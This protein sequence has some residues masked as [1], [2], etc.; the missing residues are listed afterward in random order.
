MHVEALRSGRTIL[1]KLRA[2]QLAGTVRLDLACGLTEFP[3]EIFDLADSLEIL[4]LSGNALS[5]LPDDLPRLDKLR[6]LFCSGNQFTK[7]PEVLGQCK[8]LTMLGFKANQISHVPEAALAPSLQW[9][10]LTDNRIRQLPHSIG[11]CKQMQK[12]MLAGNQLSDLPVELA[13]CTRLELLRLSANQFTVLPPWLLGMPNLA[14]LALAGNP[15]TDGFETNRQARQINDIDWQN[16]TLGRQLG[17]GASGVIY[18]AKLQKTEGATEDVAVKL[19][20][21]AV[22]SDG[23]PRCEMAAC[24][25]VDAHPHVVS[26]MGR[27]VEHPDG[28][29]GLVMPL[30]APRFNNLAAPP[31]LTSCTRD[32]YASD[33]VSTLDV[34]LRIAQGVASAA[35]HLHACGLIHGDV[36]GHNILVDATGACMLG[37]F[38][39]AAFLPT[40]DTDTAQ[41]LQHL[42]VRAFGILLGELL[43]LCKPLTPQDTALTSTLAAL[44]VLQ[45]QCT[46]KAVSHRPDFEDIERQLTA[47]MQDLNSTAKGQ[48]SRV[49]LG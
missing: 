31:S 35:G 8:Q 26:S 17:E 7:L 9:L 2:G 12:L 40:D 15:I 36:Y 22:T 49:K 37:D 24:M 21:S 30:I 46:Q 23:L 42:E 19:F 34:A 5:S 3:C 6:I 28:I 32:V 48:R 18:Q 16:I 1:D 33:R 10:I 41:A 29:Q 47:L 38:G 45:Q 20:K 13:A 43:A 11:Q 4:N 27:I 25:A 14:W 39:A 44:G